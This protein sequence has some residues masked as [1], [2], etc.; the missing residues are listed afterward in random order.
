MK[1]PYYFFDLAIL[2]SCYFYDFPRL[3]PGM[4][5]ARHFLA[6]HVIY[7][8]R[9]NPEIF[10]VL[11]LYCPKS[12]LALK[13][14]CPE[15]F[16]TWEFFLPMKFFIFVFFFFFFFFFFL[17]FGFSRLLNKIKETSQ[18][19]YNR[20]KGYLHNKLFTFTPTYELHF[21]VTEKFLLVT[22]N[23]Q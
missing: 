13:F 11:K 19:T 22:N 6:C 9:L 21:Q 7:L 23:G 14:Y 1:V 5:L 16:W 3:W 2:L 20:F 18:K 8:P 4:F 15:F 12:F 17:F 10:C